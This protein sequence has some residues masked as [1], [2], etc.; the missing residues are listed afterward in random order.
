MKPAPKPTK[1]KTQSGL[2]VKSG[3][4]TGGIDPGGNHS[5]LTLRL[6]AAADRRIGERE[7]LL[8][9]WRAGK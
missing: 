3:I 4:R 8:R 2:K 9:G 5:R 6:L 1:P 7:R